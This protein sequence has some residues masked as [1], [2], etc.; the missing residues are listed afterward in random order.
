MREKSLERH[1]CAVAGWGQRGW[2]GCWVVGLINQGAGAGWSYGAV[3]R[4]STPYVVSVAKRVSYGATVLS[5]AF[6]A[7]IPAESRVWAQTLHGL[8]CFRAF[9][10]LKHSAHVPS[11][12]APTARIRAMPAP[13]PA[14]SGHHH[15]HPRS[16]L[17]GVSAPRSKATHV[18]VRQRLSPEARCQV[19]ASCR[20]LQAFAFEQ[21]FAGADRSLPGRHCA[22]SPAVTAPHCCGVMMRKGVAR[23]R[24]RK[25]WF[26]LQ[27]PR[28]DRQGGD[29]NV[30]CGTLSLRRDLNR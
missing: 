15:T 8:H 29:A 27:S 5:V 11:V 21:F 24:E 13:V 23:E 1:A 12:S 3:G 16:R 7:V 28:C 26:A 2:C 30:Q 9:C 25:R 22:Q 14:V 6:G 4:L 18:F 17:S 19:A 10:F 20:Q